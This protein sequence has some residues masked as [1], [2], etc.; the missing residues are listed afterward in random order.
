[1]ASTQEERAYAS[2]P[3]ARGERVHFDF[4]SGSIEPTDVSE[5]A[6]PVS[7]EAPPPVSAAF[8]GEIMERE[9]VAVNPP[10]APTFKPR[11]TGFPAHKKRTNRVSAFKQQRAGG[12][13]VSSGPQQKTKES[14]VPPDMTP[15][16][17]PNKSALDDSERKRIDE[18]NNQRLANMSPEEIEQ[19]RKELFASLDP[20][21]I[22]MLLKRSN[23][24]DGTNEADWDAP[25]PGPLKENQDHAPKES[26][27]TSAKKVSFVTP[28]DEEPR[29]ASTQ[30]SSDPVSPPQLDN[31]A[32]TPLSQPDLHSDLLSDLDNAEGSIH[33]P[34][35]SQPPTL[36]PNSSTFLSDLHKKYF[37]TLPYDPAALSWMAPLDPTDTSSP[38]HP[39]HLALDPHELRFDF[40]ARLLPPSKAHSIP[41]TAG[42]HHHGDA[43]EAAGYT[44][45]E[46]ARLSRSA[47]PT[48]RC[49]AYQTLG[50]LLFRLGI[51][52]YGTES[53]GAGRERA[54]AT[55][56]WNCVEEFK[57]VETLTEEAGRMRGHL[58]AKTFAEEALWNWRRGG[59][60]KR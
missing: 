7:D 4:D 3:I 21:L 53:E 14:G 38:Y 44:I 52:E 41:V 28:E 16:R 15:P 35:P 48:Q 40:N 10:S 49:I 18:E 30:T 55:G 57:V 8:V 19:E 37:P 29:Q 46:L 33:F 60:R 31:T 1:M 36:D 5:N 13:Q 12:N 50:R 32:Q 25:Y 58:T 39:S 6:A 27:S 22:S 42:L 24:E 56:L 23:I 43:P 17:T 9:S 2:M 51:G 26:K 59:G 11:A 47:V 54:M 20:S 34:T 45:P